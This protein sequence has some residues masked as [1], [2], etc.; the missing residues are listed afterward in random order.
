MLALDSFLIT[1]FN[2]I[3]FICCPLPL[4][5]YVECTA[6]LKIVYF[7]VLLEVPHNLVLE[8]SIDSY[9]ETLQNLKEHALLDISHLVYVTVKFCEYNYLHLA[10][11]KYVS[12]CV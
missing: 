4:R 2:Y 3:L 10:S 1:I 12:S 11:T 6:S 9:V 5:V 8:V 7:V